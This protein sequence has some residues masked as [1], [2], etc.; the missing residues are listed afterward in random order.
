VH[1]LT[2][3]TH[4]EF[5]SNLENETVKNQ[6]KPDVQPQPVLLGT[7]TPL[8]PDQNQEHRNGYGYQTV[9]KTL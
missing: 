4:A 2:G 6:L 1:S 5:G 9:S 7:P 8:D 3:L